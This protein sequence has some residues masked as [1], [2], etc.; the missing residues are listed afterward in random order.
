MGRPEQD[1]RMCLEIAGRLQMIVASVEYRLAPENPFPSALEDAHTVLHWLLTNDIELHVDPGRIAVGGG[2]AGGGLAAALAQRIHDEG[3][4]TLALQ[5]LVYP[6]LDDATGSRVAPSPQHLR[7]WTPKS[8]R[9][10][11]SSYLGSPADR[12]QDSR[13][14]VPARRTDLAGLAPAWIGVGAEDLFHDEDA[15]YARKLTTSGVSA[16]LVVVPGAFHGFDAV[17]PHKDVSRRFLDQQVT[18]LSTALFP[19]A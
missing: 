10:G 2:S 7:I 12:R 8:N 14:A 6:M 17:F 4:I 16:H 11:W 15:E 18:A 1:D 19:E 5:L 9:F 13:Y 3:Q